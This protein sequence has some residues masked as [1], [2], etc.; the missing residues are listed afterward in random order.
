MLNYILMLKKFGLPKWRSGKESVCKCKGHRRGG[1][2]PWAGRILWRKKW[3]YIPVFLPR[4]FLGQRSL[5]GYSPWGHKRVGH[6]GMTE[7]HKHTL[8]DTHTHMHKISQSEVQNLYTMKTYCL[9][10]PIGIQK[11]GKLDIRAFFLLNQRI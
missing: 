7:H 8:T 3:Q 4:K 11:T 10:H 5:A 9:F 6:G 2:N 1:T